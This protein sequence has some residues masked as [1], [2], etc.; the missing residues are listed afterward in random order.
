MTGT[1]VE[2]KQAQHR[3]TI[4]QHDCAIRPC[5]MTELRNM[6]I[7]NLTLHESTTNWAKV[8][9][10]SQT[11]A[12]VC[13]IMFRVPLRQIDVQSDTLGLDLL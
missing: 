7:C 5:T 13:C 10:T 11:F 3:I 6:T 1:T 4:G 8:T 9:R 2:I 12:F